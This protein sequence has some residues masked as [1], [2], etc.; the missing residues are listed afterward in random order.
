MRTAL[1]TIN[2]RY[3]H[4]A[5]ALRYLKANLGELREQARIFEFVSGARTETIAE[6]LLNYSPSVI[7]LSVY[8]WNVEEL[9]RLAG[10]LK[11]LAPEVI[12]VIGGPE[13]SH[14]TELQPIFSLCDY[15]ITGAAEHAFARLCAQLQSGKRPMLKKIA[16]DSLLTEGLVLPYELYNDE[17][18]RNRFI[19]LEASRGCPF[20]CEFCLSA[21]DKTAVPFQMEVFLVELAKLY[22]RG[23]RS[24]KFIDRTFNLRLDDCE[25]L[26]N[27][28][29]ERLEQQQSADLLLHFE[30]I[31]DHLPERLRGL[32]AKFPPGTLQFEIGIQTWNPEVQA[33][34]S[35]RQNNEK[36]EANLIWLRESSNAHLHVDL[37]AGL[38]GETLESFAAGFDRLAR[39]R[40][41]EIQVGI[42]K[43]LRGTPIIRHTAQ[44][45][46]RFNPNPPYNLV[47]SSLIPFAEMQQIQRFARYWDLIGNSGDFAR[48]LPWLL[49]INAWIRTTNR[50]SDL[51]LCPIWRAFAVDLRPYRQHLSILGASAVRTRQNL[52]RGN[53]PRSARGT[54]SAGD[55]SLNSPEPASAKKRKRVGRNTGP[56]TL[57]RK[58]T[59]REPAWPIAA[60]AFCHAAR[61]SGAFADIAIS[62]ETWG[63]S[64]KRISNSA[65]PKGLVIILKV[66]CADCSTWV[67]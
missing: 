42:L 53:H 62:L 57:R 27:F 45:D 20:K 31:P 50:R 36:S 63:K 28:F 39:L 52:D 17:D 40:P 38:P 49:G 12:L 64:W 11:T 22:E 66:E 55:R 19:Y 46:L 61:R 7:A 3:A 9:T 44:Y 37:I 23:A 35:R 4:S 5:L 2:A 30:L 41:H 10:L 48:T 43:R 13:V 1:A 26:L 18:I 32:I 51:T 60:S 14:E 21:L 33:R 16:G 25:R 65:N 15:V 47:S 59:C 67:R 34:I 54:A 8:I 29:L 6:E 56:W 58:R 24:F